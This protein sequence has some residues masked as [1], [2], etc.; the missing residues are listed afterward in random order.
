MNACKILKEKRNDFVAFF[1]GNTTSKLSKEEFN[2]IIKKNNLE[3]HVKYLGPKYG[4]EKASIFR[5]SD[6]FI[7][8][9][10][11][12][13]ECFPV[14]IIEAMAHGMPIIST[15]EGAIPEMVD[16]GITGFLVNRKNAEEVAE[17]I[18]MLIND[19][20]RRIK[21]GKAA[22]KKYEQNYTIE[23]FNLNFVK[24]IEDIIRAD[25]IQL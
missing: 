15:K 22:R 11:Y 23:K 25:Q 3:D 20:V 9:T 17:K 10:F 19:P 16:D 8:P 14:V 6:L 5:E 21:M 1:V 18:D 7:F 13:V 12:S 24:V 4:V 2:N